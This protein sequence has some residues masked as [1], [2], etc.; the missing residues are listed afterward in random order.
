MNSPAK[1]ARYTL[2]NRAQGE[3]QGR[4]SIRAVA[5]YQVITSPRMRVR[6][7]N[8]AG[9]A[10]SNFKPGIN[11]NGRTAILNESL[12]IDVVNVSAG[13]DK[14]LVDLR[15]SQMTGGQ[16]SGRGG[17]GRMEGVQQR[18]HHVFVGLSVT[19]EDCGVGGSGS[20]SL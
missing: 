3:V 5:E 13:V 17:G 19:S 18:A 15:E 16:G 2:A 12:S 20:G 1:I 8:I 7:F 10:W 9:V 4:P 6:H 11:T 14:A